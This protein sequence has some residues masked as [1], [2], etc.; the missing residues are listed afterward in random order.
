MSLLRNAERCLANQQ[1]FKLLHAIVPRTLDGA[2]LQK[3]TREADIRRNK[4]NFTTE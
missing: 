1:A 3:Q 2:W 4:G